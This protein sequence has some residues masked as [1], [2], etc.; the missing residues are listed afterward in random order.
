[1]DKKYPVRIGVLINEHINNSEPFINLE[2]ED[3]I[4]SSWQKVVGESIAAYTTRLYMRN[5][6]LYVGFASPLVRAEFMRLRSSVLYQ[7]NGIVKEKYVK[8]IVVLV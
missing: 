2:K 3:L 5:R 7:L 4:M 6:K 1:M 8:L